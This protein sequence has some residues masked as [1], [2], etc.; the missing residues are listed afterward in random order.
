VKIHHITV[1]VFSDRKKTGEL[2]E[3]LRSILPK[4]SVIE[5]NVIEPETEGGVFTHEMVELKAGVTRQ[6]DIRKFAAT[7]FGSLDEYDRR[8]ML[9]NL[10]SYVDDECNLYVRISKSEAGGGNIV[11]ESKDSIHITF[12]LAA[13]P[14]R[15]EKAVEVAGELIEDGVH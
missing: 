3:T 6:G 7:I 11:L 14:A 9:Q 2:E 13:Y 15:K 8:R 12:K 5:E 10:G 4:D 1:S